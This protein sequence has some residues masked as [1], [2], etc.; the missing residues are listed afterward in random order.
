MIAALRLL[1]PHLRKYRGVLVIAVAAMLGEIATA[2][3]APIPLQRIIDSVVRPALR[4]GTGHLDRGKVTLLVIL[5]LVAALIAMV[6]AALNYVDLRC[7]TTVAQRAVTDLRRALFAHVQ[8]LSL[9][10]HRGRDTRSGDV[11]AR[12]SSDVQTIQDTTPAVVSSALTNTGTVAMMVTLLLVLD[13]RVGLMVAATGLPLYVVVRHYHRRLKHATR[14][15]RRHEGVITSTVSETLGTAILVKAFGREREVGQRIQA[16]TEEGL[17]L[18]LAAAEAQARFQPAVALVTALCVAAVLLVGA[19]LAMDGTITVGQLTL[20]VAYTKGIF[21]ALKQL[22]KLSSQSARAGAAAERISEL[23]STA[24]TIIDPVRP[25]AMPPARPLGI[26]FRNVTVGYVE[27]RPAVRA[28]S[29]ELPAGTTLALVGP[30]GAGKSTLLSLVPRFYDPW[31]GS[32]EIG[33]VD[34]RD[35]ALAGLRAHIALVLQDT[36]L[37]RDTVYNNIAYGRPGATPEEVMAAAE[38]AGV[39]RFVDQLADGFDTIVSERGASLSG[40]Q[41]QCVAIARALLRDAPIVLLDEPTSNLDAITEKIVVEGMRRLIEGRTAIIVAHRPATIAHADLVAE[42]DRGEVV[43][44]GTPWQLGR[45]SK[46]FAELWQETG[47][48]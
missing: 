47:S 27:G 6:D 7:S 30:T 8:R 16:E 2:V 41:K 33:G 4:H 28:V 42:L 38:T 17:L 39:T 32:V 34:V 44:M 26:T 31:Q 14:L 25:V 46:L 22:A 35:V 9:A 20:V 45:T 15:A 29:V 40:G 37:N 18:S 10:F 19:V 1:R 5:V 3:L 36:L 23:F 13:A 24:P 12:L 21:G 11:L 48:A 43:R